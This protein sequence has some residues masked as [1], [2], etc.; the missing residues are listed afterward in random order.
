MRLSRL[1]RVLA[2]AT[3][4]PLALAQEASALEPTPGPASEAAPSAPAPSAPAPS[5][6]A[7]SAPAPSAPAPSAPAPSAPGGEEA[8]GSDGAAEPQ[9]PVGAGADAQGQARVAEPGA[10]SAEVTRPMPVTAVAPAGPAPVLAPAATPPSDDGAAASTPRA[11]LP[12]T[13]E[14]KLGLSLRPGEAG[15][16]DEESHAGAEV[17]LALCLELEP[18]LAVGLELERAAL[19]RGTGISGLSSVTADYSATSALVG[20]RAYPFRSELV[21]LFVGLQVG[22]GMQGISAG[23][24]RADGALGP[25]L[26]YACSA[27]DG[28]AFQIGGN[29]GARLMLTPRWGVTARVGGLGRRLTDDVVDGCAR[30]IGTTTT[31]SAGLALGYD[32]DLDP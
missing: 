32:F 7:P 10:P 29:V 15:G 14:G 9:V 25:S 30:G 4:A 18:E 26:T 19:G 22:V 24:T 5:A 13:L 8:A 20:L 27:S 1:M 2:I 16:F 28:P 12:L 23:G 11:R 17:G 6:P 21:D 31:I 3:A